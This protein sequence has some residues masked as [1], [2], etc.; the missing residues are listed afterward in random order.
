MPSDYENSSDCGGGGPR[1]TLV[2]AVIIV[3][4]VMLGTWWVKLG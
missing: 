2:V 3:A 4:I 1:W